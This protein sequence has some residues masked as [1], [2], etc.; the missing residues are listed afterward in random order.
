M[1]EK[2]NTKGPQKIRKTEHENFP[3]IMI[4]IQKN[5]RRTAPLNTTTRSANSRRTELPIIVLVTLP[6]TPSIGHECD[7]HFSALSLLL[8]IS[9]SPSR[10]LHYLLRELSLPIITQPCSDS[11]SLSNSHSYSHSHSVF[12]HSVVGSLD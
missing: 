12:S 2:Q 4:I 5:G 9:L 6:K 8:S 3:Q 11:L 1:K 10:S 7:F